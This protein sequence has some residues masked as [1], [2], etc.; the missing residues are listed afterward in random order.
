ME[1]PN[2]ARYY[3]IFTGSGQTNWC[4]IV[5]ENQSANIQ[6]S[7]ESLISSKNIARLKTY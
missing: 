6:L 4:F 7:T 1:K 2:I 3:S 5:S